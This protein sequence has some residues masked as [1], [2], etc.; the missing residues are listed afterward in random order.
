[1]WLSDQGKGSAWG[2]DTCPGSVAS[3]LPS[4]LARGEEQGLQRL[5][6]E[7]RSEAPLGCWQFQG[8]GQDG[9]GHREE[10]GQGAV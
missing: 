8:K 6:E 3:S 2:Q 4:W 7:A 1:M 5:G 9:F 10:A